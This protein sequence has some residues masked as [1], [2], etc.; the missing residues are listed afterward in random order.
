MQP[1]EGSAQEPE[2]LALFACSDTVKDEAA[3]VV[4]YLRHHLKIDVHMVAFLILHL[5]V[6]RSCCL[7]DTKW[8][9]SQ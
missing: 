6:S 8:I 9:Q 5:R 4:R 2:L 1:A 7:S 3:E